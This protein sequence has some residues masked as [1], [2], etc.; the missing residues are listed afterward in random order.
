VTTYE[1]RPGDAR[2]AGPTVQDLYDEDSRPVPAALR[3]TSTAYQ[4]S[5]DVPKSRYT[6]PEFAALE[7][8]YVWK[9]TWQYA[10]RE[11]DIPDSGDHVVY[12]VA[13]QSLIVTR[14]PE[15]TIKAFHNSCLHRGTKL[16]MEDGRVA[17]FRCPFHGWRWGLDG[18][19]VD[20]PADWDFPHITSD[21]TLSCLPE[22][23]VATGA[24]FVFVNFDVQAPPFEQV[25]GKLLQHLADFGFEQRYKAFHAVKE[26]P[27]NWKVCMEAFSEAYHV[28]ATHPQILEFCADTNSEYSIWPTDPYVTRFVNAF[29]AHSPHLPDLSEQHVADAYVSF[30]SGRRGPMETVSL[31]EG[32]KARTAV[33]DRL[34]ERIQTL[35]G[36]DLSDTADTVILDAILY[37][38]FPAFAPWAGVGQSLTYRWRPGPTPDSCYMDVL[39]LVP[40][41]DEGDVP[42]SA[43]TTVLR[44]DQRWNEAPG[45]GGLADVFEQDMSNLPRVQAGLK[46][47]GKPGVSFGNYQEGRLRMFHRHLDG[48]I[49]Q[50]LAKDGRSAD[51]LAP[52]RIPEG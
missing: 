4:G 14:T 50:G 43:E 29:G 31:E 32:A 26:V 34:R 6:S 47:T 9:H 2:S 3:D 21:P 42:E 36:T 13:D 20:L 11:A 44:L 25:A 19:L 30:Q 52:F 17:S 33:A 7:A 49:L 5:A 51:E 48:L 12:D 27:C 16:R 35:Y 24:G 8:E 23:Q 28:I 37:H 10:C 38:L 18:T 22:A 41:P 46:S 1:Q 15:G 40:W 39:R 45:M